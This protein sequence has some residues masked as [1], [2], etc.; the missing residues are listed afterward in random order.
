MVVGNVAGA[1]QQT[2]H[3]NDDEE[4][5][6]PTATLALTRRASFAGEAARAHTRGLGGRLSGL[7]RTALTQ[8]STRHARSRARIRYLVE[9][10][11]R[12]LSARRLSDWALDIVARTRLTQGC[13]LSG[14]HSLVLRH[15]LFVQLGVGVNLWLTGVN[16]AA[17]TEGVRGR[18]THACAPSFGSRMISSPGAR[19]PMRSSSSACSKMICAAT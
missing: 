14:C 19:P 6:H 10:G 5:T 15:V 17:R 8:R 11:K 18:R 7:R 16:L 13:S 3:H 4:G 2:E 9:G 1:G 12:A